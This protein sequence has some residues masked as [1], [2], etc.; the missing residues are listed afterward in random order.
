MKSKRWLT[1]WLT[2]CVF[3]AV[4]TVVASES[5]PGTPAASSVRSPDSGSGP[6]S[7]RDSVIAGCTG[8]RVPLVHPTAS[9]P[10]ASDNS[11]RLGSLNPRRTSYSA[12]QA[13]GAQPAGTSIVGFWKFTFTAEGNATIPDGTPVDVGFVQWH[14]DG[15]EI[16]NSSRPPV[17]QSFCLGVWSRTGGASYTLNHFALSWDLDNNFVGPANIRE[18]IT[19][20]RGGQSYAGSFTIDQFDGSG[21]VLAH[22]AGKVTGTRITVDTTPADIR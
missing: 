16:M 22:V 4:A 12:A 8:I 20:D 5:S 3:A 13:V 17:T 6:Q 11:P 21:H 2:A 10:T 18:D 1:A 9:G 15:T 19:V 7:D 14:S